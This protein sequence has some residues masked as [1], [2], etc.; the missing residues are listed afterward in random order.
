MKL[1]PQV[2][3]CMLPT[4]GIAASKA[5]SLNITAVV[6]ANSVA[7]LEFWK[8]S[9]LPVFSRGAVN[10]DLGDLDD[11]LIGIIPQNTTTGTD[12]NYIQA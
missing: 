3:N 5:A 10:V 6:A 4:L 11:A 7:R 2:V 9:A 12:N 1:T 8:L